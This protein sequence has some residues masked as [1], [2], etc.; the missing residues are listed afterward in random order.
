MTLRYS[1][2]ALKQAIWKLKDVEQLPDGFDRT[3]PVR[4]PEDLVRQLG[5]LFKDAAQ[6]MM[7]VVILSAR[8]YV[9]AIDIISTGTLNASL[10]HPREVFRCA[11]ANLAASII[12]MHNHPSGNPEPSQEDINITRQLVESGRVLGI[13]VHDHVIVAGDSYSSMAERGQL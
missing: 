1:K 12:V 2:Y 10:A 8:N 6:E 11:V 3:M 5:F 9:Q 4:S 7:I 13:P